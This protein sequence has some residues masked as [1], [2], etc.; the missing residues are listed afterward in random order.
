MTVSNPILLPNIKE[1]SFSQFLYDSLAFSIPTHS[2]VAAHHTVVSTSHS[3][4]NSDSHASPMILSSVD[5]LP[6]A[7]TH[8]HAHAHAHGHGDDVLTEEEETILTEIGTLDFYVHQYILNRMK[9]I[10]SWLYPKTP[11]E[12][13]TERRLI[14]QGEHYAFLIQSKS[15]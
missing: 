15:K 10:E 6:H 12:G 13:D 3:G 2:T 1:S 11:S 9:L 7:H 5:P 8:A 4:S 14:Q